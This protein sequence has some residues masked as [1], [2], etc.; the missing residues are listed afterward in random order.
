MSQCTPSTTIIILKKKEICQLEDLMST[1]DG[2][3]QTSLG[4]QFQGSQSEEKRLRGKWPDI[5][6]KHSNL[7]RKWEKSL[8]SVDDIG[9][10]KQGQP[11]KCQRT[12]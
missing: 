1:F 6:Q 11:R 2:P 4:M 8:G 7:K 3:F 12:I 10:T 5:L 9:P